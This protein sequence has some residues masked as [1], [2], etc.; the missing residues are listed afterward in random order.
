MQCL[1]NNLRVRAVITEH[2]EEV[3]MDDSNWQCVF[4]LISEF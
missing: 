4:L 2:M 3:E 1:L